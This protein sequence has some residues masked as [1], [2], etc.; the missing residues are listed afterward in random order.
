ML[1][2][3]RARVNPRKD[4]R[5]DG[6][7]IKCRLMEARSIEMEQ[8]ANDL[9]ERAR[10]A[11]ASHA[12]ALSIAEVG[13]S[14]S[15]RLGK[16]ESIEREDS[17]G[18][19]LRV[20][21]EQPGGMAFATAASAD[22]SPEGLDRLARQAVEM[23]RIAEP[24]PDAVP[25]VGADHPGPEELAEWLARHPLPEHLWTLEQAREA[26]LACEQAA[27][28]ASSEV[29]NSE[30]A[31]A[32]FGTAR[33]AYASSDGFSASFARAN[34]ALSVSVVAGSID[35]MQRDYAWHQAPDRKR[36]REPGDLG[37][38]AAIRAVRRLGASPIESGRMP[39][40]FEPRTAASLLG[41]LAGAI[42]GRAVLQHRS[43]LADDLGK[44][45][46]AESV[47]IVDDPAHPDGLSPQLFDGEG[48]RCARLAIVERGR[49]SHFLT[50]RYAAR[51]LKLAPTG[52]AR[53]GLTGDISIGPSNLIWQPGT[54][55]PEELIAGIERGLLVTELIGFGV[56]PV[57]GDYSRGA[58]GFLI[59][60]GR[61]ARPVQGVTI[62]G[63]LKA[64]FAGVAGIGSDLTWF[65][66]RA[67]PS[68]VIE[69]MTIAGA[70]RP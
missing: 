32:G 69:G 61:V 44:P 9:I 38:E 28:D 41:H 48:S 54:G 30:G 26:A 5:F 16:V 7:P 2:R 57:T 56:N 53:R 25:P 8:K 10:R 63:N 45:V 66:S 50:D 33:I 6:Q 12:D 13:E 4:W 67:C 51:R 22:A 34:L 42:N 27:L 65:G 46:F 59:E 68:L 20:F 62:A 70:S 55:S 3:R 17:F 64:M 35:R 49:L 58:A 23:A 18:I 19:G 43:F 37:R 52:H 15:V 31:Q 47:D 39:V 24:D 60:Q 36:L 14:V 21:I 1:G 40:V 11:G 29:R